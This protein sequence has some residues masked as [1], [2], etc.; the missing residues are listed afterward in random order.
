LLNILRK[1]NKSAAALSLSQ[2]RS[3]FPH[4][5]HGQRKKVAPSEDEQAQ[6]PEALEGKPPQEAHMAEVIRAAGPGARGSGCA[7]PLT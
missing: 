1:R 5:D 7:R 4:F 3:K 6:A 2:Y